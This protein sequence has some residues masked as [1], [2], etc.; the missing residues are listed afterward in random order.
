MWVFPVPAGPWRNSAGKGNL[1]PE[2]A[3]RIAATDSAMPGCNTMVSKEY[4]RGVESS[5]KS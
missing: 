4:R 2:Y 3:E 5:S 1:A